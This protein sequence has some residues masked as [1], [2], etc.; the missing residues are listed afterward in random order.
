LKLALVTTPW[1]SA[2]RAGAIARE[3]VR[4]LADTEQIEVF[5]ERGREGGDYFGWK[6]RSASALVPREHDHVLHFVADEPECAFVLPL[7]RELGGCAV[8]LDWELAAAARAAYPELAASGLRGVIRALREGGFDE[9]R[10]YAKSRG[11]DR[12][13]SI[14]LNRSIVRFADSFFAPSESLR[15]LILDSRNAP[16]PVGVLDFASANW[17]DLAHAVREQLERFPPPRTARKGLLLRRVRE[18]LR[19]G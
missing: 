14:S 16:T 2:S 11:G 3:L 13:A 17:P 8:L 4:H 19:R 7:V 6:A 18:E 5:V 1:N 15:E 9:A 12:P 10:R